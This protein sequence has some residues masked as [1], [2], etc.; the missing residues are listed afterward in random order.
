M[1]PG[2]MVEANA[3]VTLTLGLRMQ[4]LVTEKLMTLSEQPGG[5]ISDPRS[6]IADRGRGGQRREPALTSG[7][8]QPAASTPSPRP[9]TQICPPCANQPPPLHP[10]P[11]H[12]PAMRRTAQSSCPSVAGSCAATPRFA[13]ALSIEDFNVVKPISRG[14]FGRVY[15]AEKKSTGGCCG[16]F[17]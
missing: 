3:E 5:R 2:D 4:A 16:F 12:P 11:S 17:W 13:P 9:H 1:T 15:L 7:A 14:A 10:P 6:Q 8:P